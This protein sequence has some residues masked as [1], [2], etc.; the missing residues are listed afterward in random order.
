MSSLD[1][2]P[3]PLA[4]LDERAAA[5]M[6][7]VS[8]DFLRKFRRTGG[9]PAYLRLGRVIRYR[10]VDLVAWLEGRKFQ[11]SAEEVARGA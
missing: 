9:G 6:L 7:S 8:P 10:H 11:S 3:L 2:S 1:V 4:A 5:R